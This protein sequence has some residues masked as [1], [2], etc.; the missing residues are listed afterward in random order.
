MTEL[1]ILKK[2]DVRKVW[3]HE[4]RDFSAWLVKPENLEL[5]SEQL[6]IDIEPTGTEIGVGRFR[7]DILAEEPRTGHKIIIENQLESTNHDHL[8]K[9]ITYAAGIDAKYI[10]WIV[11]DILPEHLKAVEWLNEHLDEEIRCFL[12]RIE[13]WQIGDSKPAPRFELIS[14]KNDWAATLKSSSVSTGVS[15]TKLKQQEYWRGL[16]EY[17]RKKDQ[18]IKLNTPRPQHWL[19]FSMGNSLAHIALTLNTQ[20]NIFGCDL[21]ISNDKTLYSYL[22]DNSEQIQAELGEQFEWFEGKVAAGLGVYKDVND[23]FQE[24]KLEENYE[25]MYERVLLFKKVF[26]PYINVYKNERK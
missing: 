8:G 5:L 25:W 9:V 6:G 19:S 22:N 18:Q 15:T 7:I 2:V 1:G 24:E 23:V 17:I 26:T 20:K 14:V 10:I 3:E 11:N 4:A 12:I 16:C 13:V 21:Y